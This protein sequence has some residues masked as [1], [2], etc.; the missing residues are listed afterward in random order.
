MAVQ[1]RDRTTEIEQKYLNMAEEYMASR[2]S[3]YEFNAN[4]NISI[5]YSGEI[6]KSKKSSNVDLNKTSAKEKGEVVF[7]YSGSSNVSKNEGISISINAEKQINNDSI[8]GTTTYKNGKIEGEFSAKSP[9]GSAEVTADSL[10]VSLGKGKN[11]ISV[12]KSKEGDEQ[13][14]SVLGGEISRTSKPDNGGEKRSV[15]YKDSFSVSAETNYTD[16]SAL[17]YQANLEVGKLKTGI[18][19]HNGYVEQVSVGVKGKKEKGGWELKGEFEASLGKPFERAREDLAYYFK[20]MEDN[21]INKEK[22][23]KLLDNNIKAGSL[24][25]KIDDIATSIVKSIIRQ[26]TSGTRVWINGDSAKEFYENA[27]AKGINGHIKIEV[28][29][30]TRISN[31][32][33][34]YGWQYFDKIAYSASNLVASGLSLFGWKTPKEIVEQYGEAQAYNNANLNVMA[35]LD[36][37]ASDKFS[38][39][40]TKSLNDTQLKSKK[41]A[42]EVATKVASNEVEENSMKL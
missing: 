41:P 24:G 34:G 11:Q 4:S 8:G 27:V 9:W 25:G 23:I 15:Q 32:F 30:E 7:G 28:P 5:S 22:A 29:S 17:K 42:Q 40:H 39:K 36:K 21:G 16:E 35:K 26:S 6:E 31:A 10:S 19:L 33:G 38:L 14:L 1:N 3:T 20:F 2:I 18:G 12:K 13:K 37:E